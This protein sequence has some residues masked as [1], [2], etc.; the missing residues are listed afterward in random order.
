MLTM[1]EYAQTIVKKTGV[2]GGSVPASATAAERRPQ[3]TQWATVDW[4]DR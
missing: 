1:Q 3:R 2:A 4:L